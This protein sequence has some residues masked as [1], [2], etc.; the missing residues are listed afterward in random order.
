MID[1]S[2]ELPKHPTMKWKEREEDKITHLIVHC[3]AS[4]NQDPVKT[5]NYHI[6]SKALSKKGAPGIAYHDFITN[7]GTIYHCNNYN[8]IT[9]HAGLYNSYSVGVVIAYL[10]EPNLIPNKQWEFLINHL[11]ELCLRFKINP[12]KKLLGHK[13][14]IGMFIKMGNGSV[15]YYKEC[16]FNIDKLNIMR[17]EVLCNVSFIGQK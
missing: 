13:E 17:R 3:T 9:W 6:N 12:S 1:I 7:T 8:K 16:P 4:N 14:C 5:A 10:G 15:R 11:T 2:N